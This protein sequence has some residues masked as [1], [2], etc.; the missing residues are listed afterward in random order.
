MVWV[1]V[2][3]W[4]VFTLPRELPQK[5]SRVGRWWWCWGVRKA[6]VYGL[7]KAFAARKVLSMHRWGHVV[8]TALVLVADGQARRWGACVVGIIL[9]DIQN[10]ENAEKMSHGCL[11]IRGIEVFCFCFCIIMIVIGPVTVLSDVLSGRVHGHALMHVLR[12]SLCCM[13]WCILLK[14]ELRQAL[15]NEN[16]SF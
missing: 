11:P 15:R 8:V 7:S 16:W 14:I 1:V 13:L 6:D 5:E 2:W 10:P 12:T 3:V 9:V 4:V